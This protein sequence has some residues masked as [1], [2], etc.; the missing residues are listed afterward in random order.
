MSIEKDVYGLAQLTLATI[1]IVAVLFLL[2]FLLQPYFHI[3]F[4]GGVV[5]FVV[6]G[7][8]YAIASGG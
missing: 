2:Y 3:I 1:V 6:I 8:I 5:A 7:G 4:W